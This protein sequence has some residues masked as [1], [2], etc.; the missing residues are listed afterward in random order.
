[1]DAAATQ[2]SQMYQKCIVGS[3]ASSFE[4]AL[5]IWSV[6][7]EVIF[8]IG[9]NLKIIHLVTSSR[10]KQSVIKS[11]LIKCFRGFYFG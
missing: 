3:L 2:V 1:M 10:I 8:C 7:N 11:F 4:R 9:Q 5:A 6:G